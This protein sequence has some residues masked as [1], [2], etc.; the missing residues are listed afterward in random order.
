[1]IETNET[2]EVNE[3]PEE[4]GAFV[5]SGPIVNPW[6]VP[7]ELEGGESEDEA[8]DG[9][10]EGSED[11]EE[12]SGKADDEETVRLGDEDV[13]RETLNKVWSDFAEAQKDELL[14]PFVAEDSEVSLLQVARFGAELS[15]HFQAQTTDPDVSFGLIGDVMARH[16]MA[17]ESSEEDDADERA[18][19]VVF[20][21]KNPATLDPEARPYYEAARQAARI[22]AKQYEIAQDLA[23]QLGEANEKIAELEQGPELLQR[24]LEKVPDA[25]ISAADLRTWMK[26][27]GT[28]N[29]EVAHAAYE[30]ERKAKG[31]KTT[32]K[33][34]AKA[35]AKKAPNQPKQ[36]GQNTFDPAGMTPGQIGAEVLRGRVPVKK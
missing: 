30:A 22:G 24:L 33:G 29:P 28:E 20:A 21:L 36:Q 26:K 25:K 10:A 3:A 17:H 27:I 16:F 5:M 19:D 4:S 34:A 11:S 32:A 35:D 18:M 14:A 8:T 23:R 2:T 15:Q 9:E 12:E 31:A 6:E 7:E 1:M 13:S